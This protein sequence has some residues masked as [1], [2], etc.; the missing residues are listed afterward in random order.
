[1]A[2]MLLEVRSDFIARIHEYPLQPQGT[3]CGCPDNKSPNMGVCILGPMII[4]NSHTHTY[5]IPPRRRAFLAIF[6]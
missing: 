6:N 2:H 5:I 3:L 1:M 4:G